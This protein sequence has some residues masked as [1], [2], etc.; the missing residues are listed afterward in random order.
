MFNYLFFVALTKYLLNVIKVATKKEIQQ[1]IEQLEK[2]I[3]L[4]LKDYLP[5]INGKSHMNS[6]EKAELDYLA[7]ALEW[8]KN[9]L[10]ELL[11]ELL[12]D[13]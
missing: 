13:E 4:L 6:K 8:R 1:K 7:A 12:A 2:D 10:Y 3:E 9:E 11:D 5:I